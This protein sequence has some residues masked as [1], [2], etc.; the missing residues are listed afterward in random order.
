MCRRLCRHYLISSSWW[1]YR[2]NSTMIISILQEAHLSSGVLHTESKRW[3]W[4]TWYLCSRKRPDRLRVHS[5][6]EG[7]VG[8][9]IERSGEKWVILCKTQRLGQSRQGHS[10]RVNMVSLLH[11]SIICHAV[12]LNFIDLLYLICI[13]VGYK[14]LRFRGIRIRCPHI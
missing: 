10:H 1:S 7:L 14:T 5:V 2:I 9:W 8:V 6:A 11:N 3:S 4:A 12:D 13:H